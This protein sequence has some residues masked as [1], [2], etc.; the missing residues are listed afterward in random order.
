MASCLSHGFSLGFHLSTCITHLKSTSGNFFP[1]ASF[2]PQIID[3]YLHLEISKGRLE[4]QAPSNSSFSGTWIY[5]HG[6]VQ[7]L[8]DSWSCPL[9]SKGLTHRLNAATGSS[10]PR[11]IISLLYWL[12]PASEK[13][14]TWFCSHLQIP[15]TIHP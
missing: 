14:F 11:R 7:P 10:L 6:Q 3:K 9:N 1:A 12:F 2:N 4:C 8:L 5:S 13:T 15:F